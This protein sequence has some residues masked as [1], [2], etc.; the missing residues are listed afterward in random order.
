MTPGGLTLL[1]TAFDA[2]CNDIDPVE[3]C[4]CITGVRDGEQLR[5][6]HTAWASARRANV[7]RPPLPTRTFL[8][9]IRNAPLDGPRQNEYNPI[10][11]CV[12]TSPGKT[13]Q[14]SV[15]TLLWAAQLPLR[16]A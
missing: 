1:A 9:R 3:S 16:E 12:K 13:A 5:R 10:T 15:R 4:L 7:P 14:P 8:V 6:D 2:Q 11:G